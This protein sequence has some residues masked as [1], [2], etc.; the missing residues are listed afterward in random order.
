MTTARSP[1]DRPAFRAFASL[2]TSGVDV[3]L[4]LLALGGPEALLAHRRALALLAAWTALGLV[5]ALLRPVRS[6]DVVDADADARGVF[7]ALG[8]VPLLVAPVA[9]VGERFGVGPLPG[10]EALRWSG[11]AL[12]ASALALR[13]A[14]IAQLGA[15]FAPIAAVQSEHALETRGLY[16]RMR[17]PGYLGSWL[18]AVGTAIAFGSAL[19]FALPLLL[20]PLFVTRIRRED[21][22]LERHF[23]DAYRAWRARTWGMFP[24]PF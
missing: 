16:S 2:V 18:T 13:I 8:L 1:M 10:G 22:L 23:G 6:S 19:G 24:K 11:V 4:L 5:L 3:L 14:A 21:A 12:S 7:V 15:R 9:A 20:A 17:H